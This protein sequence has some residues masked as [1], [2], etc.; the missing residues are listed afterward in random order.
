MVMVR[1][2]QTGQTEKVLLF[3]R[4]QITQTGKRWIADRITY[5]VADNKVIAEG[6]TKAFILQNGPGKGPTAP[7]QVSP[8][9]GPM[10]AMP[11]NTIANTQPKQASGNTKLSA[12]KVEIPK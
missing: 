6:N 5:T 7:N 8:T 1:N 11:K 12:S 4:C 3:G 9:T 2:P 10:L